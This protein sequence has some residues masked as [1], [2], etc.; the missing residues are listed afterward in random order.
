MNNLFKS[1][2]HEYEKIVNGKHKYL[3]YGVKFVD[4]Y[5]D[6]YQENAGLSYLANLGLI[7]KPKEVRIKFCEN[8]PELKL[9]HF[10]TFHINTSV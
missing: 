5:T 10:K 2:F 3:K 9:T 6:F 7:P 1:T 8:G 4:Y